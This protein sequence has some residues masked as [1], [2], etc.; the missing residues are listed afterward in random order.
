VADIKDLTWCK[1]DGTEMSTPSGPIPRCAGWPNAFGGEAID[2]RE[3]KG[4]RISDETLLVLFKQ[5]A[6]GT[7]VHTNPRRGATESCLWKS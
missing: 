5:L 2:E 4:G 6:R 7:N 1:L 3:P